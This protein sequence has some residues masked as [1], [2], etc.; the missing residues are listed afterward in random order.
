MKTWTDL[1][2]GLNWQV[3]PAPERMPWADAK[4]YAASLDLDG[5]G[6]RLATVNELVAVSPNSDLEGSGWYWSSSPVEDVARGAWVVKFVYGFVY[7]ASVNAVS[8]VRCVRQR[9]EED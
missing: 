9:P 3:T 1:E 6:W 5:G 7:V 2:T 4:K 8:L